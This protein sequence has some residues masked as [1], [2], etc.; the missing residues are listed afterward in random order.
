[1]TY[2][3]AFAIYG[4]S[5]HFRATGNKESLRTAIDIYKKMI[6][7]AYDPVN[8]GFI[9]AFTREWQMINQGSPKTMNNNLHVLE[10]LTNLYRV[11]KDPG[12]QNQLREQIDVM[13][14][15]VLDQNTW[16]ERLYLT[17]DWQNQRDIDSYGHDINFPGCLSKLPKY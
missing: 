4:L 6:E 5:E 15:K 17:M 1:M 13:S 9:E 11:W 7:Y 10:A 12:L 8:G 3:N 2:Q 16:H 14:N